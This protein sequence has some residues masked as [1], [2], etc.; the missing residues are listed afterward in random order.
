MKKARVLLACVLACSLLSAQTKKPAQKPVDS[1]LPDWRIIKLTDKMTDKQ[2]CLVTYNQRLDV[3]LVS[4]ISLRLG[5]RGR[6]GLKGYQYR[7]G[8]G[9]ASDYVQ[10][11]G[12]E[13]DTGS[14]ELYFFDRLKLSDSKSVFVRATTLLGGT[15]EQT[16][17]LTGI[18]SALKLLENC[19]AA[20]QQ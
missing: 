4:D 5:Y 9:K 20:I 1:D 19:K 3:F 12:L 11:T 2:T 16:I 13:V 10:A 14:F 6:G 15:I 17:D 8:D 18:Q 7:I